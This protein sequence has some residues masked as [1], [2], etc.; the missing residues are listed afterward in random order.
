[1]A[2]K[3]T[4]SESTSPVAEFEGSL[5]A[6]EA[7]VAQMER[8][9]LGL[10]QSLAAYEKGINLYRKCLTAL[11]QAELRVKVLNDPEN[12]DSAQSLPPLR[13]E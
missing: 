7:L 5:E 8:G 4:S 12:P 11:E 3:T 2:K 13:D 9:D 10:E 6:L 1:M